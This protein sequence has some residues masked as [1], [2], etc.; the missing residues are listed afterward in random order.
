MRLRRTAVFLSS[1]VLVASA[2]PPSHAA[3]FQWHTGTRTTGI[4]SSSH[5]FWS[6]GSRSLAMVKQCWP[7]WPDTSVV[8]ATGTVKDL[9]NDGLCGQVLIRY[10]RSTV[11]D[12]RGWACPK[13]TVSSFTGPTRAGS[14]VAIAVQNVSP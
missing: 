2:A 10:N 13:G 14:R 5:S 3:T 6:P 4:C 8:Y 7:R 11:E 1:L 9:D 12:R